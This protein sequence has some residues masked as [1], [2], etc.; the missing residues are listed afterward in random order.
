MSTS[1]RKIDEVFLTVVEQ[2]AFM[3]GDP[4]EAGEIDCYDGSWVRA[5]LDFRSRISGTLA[6][7]VPEPMSREIAANI[8]G[9]DP[10]DIA[11]DAVAEDALMEMLNV[12]AGHIV[13]ALHDAEVPFDLTVP[14]L[15]RLDHAA[16]RDLAQADHAACY[17]LDG[18]P[19]ILS[20]L[21][22]GA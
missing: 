5:S 17:G 12:V 1:T 6:L 11:N 18:T 3:F 14:R 19:V 15:E 22:S 16:C 4:C 2:L 10:E 8:L 20:V 9:L 7:T 13:P 21:P